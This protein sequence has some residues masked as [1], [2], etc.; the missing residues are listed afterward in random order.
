MTSS[1]RWLITEREERTKVRSATN[2]LAH[3][4]FC[5]L[6]VVQALRDGA[7]DELGGLGHDGLER[8]GEPL[9]GDLAVGGAQI[10][11]HRGAG[12]L[13]VHAV[14]GA[15]RHLVVDALDTVVGAPLDLDALMSAT[16]RGN[17]Y[18]S[19]SVLRRG[20]SARP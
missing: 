8:V 19:L 6:G 5:A 11:L 1:P 20:I 17:Q 13:V 10:G 4:L 12:A 14:G 9:V 16:S 7:G 2:L 3:R 15:L 18:R